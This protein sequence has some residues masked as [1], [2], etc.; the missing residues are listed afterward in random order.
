MAV[1]SLVGGPG[2]G[3]AF[4]NDRRF[5]AIVAQAVV[6]GL[7]GLLIYFVV[8]NTIY[9]LEQRNIATG[10]W[11]L[12]QPAGFEIELTL[13]PYSS[14][15]TYGRVFFVGLLNTL[16]VA[17]LGCIFATILG[18]ILGVLRLSGNW[19]LEQIIYWFVEFTRNVPLLLQIIFWYTVM[20]GLPHL[21]QSIELLDTFY[22]NNRGLFSPAPILGEKFSLVLVA[23]AGAVLAAWGVARWAKKRQAATGQ[24]FPAF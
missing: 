15:S 1:G 14:A 8:S 6:M 22:L 3:G 7:L 16:L 2:A 9:N 13:I 10:F 19:L 5:R 18:F 20:L 21:R 12:T 17:L 24:S 11:F 4:W 23:F